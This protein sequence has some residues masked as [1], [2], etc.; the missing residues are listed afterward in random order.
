MKKLIV[1]TLLMAGMT[2]IAQ[3]RNNKNQRNQKE[4]FTPEQRSELQVKKLTLELDLNASQQKEIKAFIAEKNSKMEAN[5]IAMKEMREKKTKLTNDQ[6]FEM[7]M[8][9]LDGQ[10]ASKKRMEKI[11]NATQYE[12]WVALKEDRKDHFKGRRQG[13]HPKMEQRRG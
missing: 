13:K 8:K 5:K 6:R 4:Q 12:K 9:M 11:L 7:K 3:P 1:L 10:I 2:I